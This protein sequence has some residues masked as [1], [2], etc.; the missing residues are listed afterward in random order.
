MRNILIAILLFVFCS[1]LDPVFATVTKAGPELQWLGVSSVEVY[2]GLSTDTKPTTWRGAAVKFGAAFLETNTQQIFFY[3]GSSWVCRSVSYVTSAD[4]LSTP[5]AF[6][7]YATNGYTNVMI[8]LQD[9]LYS[10][11]SITFRPEGKKSTFNWNTVDATDDS[12]VVT[13]ST[14]TYR[15]Y[16]ATAGLDS[17]RVYFWSEA[18]GANA[19]AKCIL[20]F[21]NPNK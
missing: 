6:P 20:T 17:F 11:T 12:T 8:A 10:S 5:G 1:C 18:G 3:D 16:Q 4:T 19:I 9:S 2:K 21:W 15:N 13:S 7:A 14:T